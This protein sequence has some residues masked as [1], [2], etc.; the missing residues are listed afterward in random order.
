M[1]G[2]RDLRTYP[3]ERQGRIVR[4]LEVALRRI[5]AVIRPHGVDATIVAVDG[6]GGSGTSTLAA[7]LAER[8]GAQVVHTD[9]FASWDNPLEWWP[10]LRDEVLVP[11][12]AGRPARFQ[13]YDWESRELG[14]WQIVVPD[15]L[16]VLEG[17]SSSR[18]EFCPYLSFAIWVEAAAETRLKRGLQRD[19]SAAEDQWREWMRLE[20]EWVEA[21]HPNDVADLVLD[22]EAPW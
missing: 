3:H 8:L 22:G 16:V 5:D 2:A 1:P 21:Q 14:D 17:V 18:K 20:D 6:L 15:E 13:R 9:D 10:R 4:Q 19:G 7:L 12:A 11:L